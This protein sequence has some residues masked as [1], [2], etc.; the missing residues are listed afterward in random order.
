MRQARLARQ[1][2]HAAAGSGLRVPCAEYHARIEYRADAHGAGLQRR[3]ERGAAQ[4]VILE[5]LRALAQRDDLG[6]G[7][8]VEAADRT[9]PSLADHISPHHQKRAYRYLAVARSLLCE[10][11]RLLHEIKISRRT[12]CRGAVRG[13]RRTLRVTTMAANTMN[14]AAAL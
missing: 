5:P 14:R 13:C 7:G 9:V 10:A 12:H 1:I 4:A 3:I 2:N 8:R 6:M 11:Q